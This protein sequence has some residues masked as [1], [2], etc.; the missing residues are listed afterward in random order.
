MKKNQLKER[1]Q[2][3]AGVKKSLKEQDNDVFVQNANPVFAC[4]SG[5]EYETGD[6]MQGLTW[7]TDA[8]Q[9]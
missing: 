9:Y 4:V 6:E 8:S 5:T 1:F 2:K 7:I 3:L